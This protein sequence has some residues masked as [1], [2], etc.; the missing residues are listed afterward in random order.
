MSYYD[1]LH[2]TSCHDEIACCLYVPLV[3]VYQIRPWLASAK[4]TSLL[5]HSDSPQYGFSIARQLNMSN[6]A[7]CRFFS[8][9]PRLYE[10]D[11]IVTFTSHDFPVAALVWADAAG[12]LRVLE[13]FYMLLNSTA[14]NACRR[15]HFRKGDVRIAA[16]KFHYP[17]GGFLTTFFLPP[18]GSPVYHVI[19]LSSSFPSMVSIDVHLPWLMP[20]TSFSVVLCSIRLLKWLA[21]SHRHG[22]QVRLPSLRRQAANKWSCPNP[23]HGLRFSPRAC[24]RERR[25]VS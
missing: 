17:V 22:R 4:I 20:I 16:D 6:V 5:F 21:S 24:V 12:A 3:V 15:D 18:C 1:F 13:P 10:K 2:T 8:G 7:S 23:R 9:I 11:V 19:I 14:R 25:H